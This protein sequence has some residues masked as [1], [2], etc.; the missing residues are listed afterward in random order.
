M[1]SYE[2]ASG[3]GL[4][5]GRFTVNLMLNNTFWCTGPQMIF[6]DSWGTL[7]ASADVIIGL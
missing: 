6:N 2:F 7:G 1:G 4:E 5:L 3:L